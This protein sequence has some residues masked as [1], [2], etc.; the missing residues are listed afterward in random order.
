[1]PT[2]MCPNC[3]ARTTIDGDRAGPLAVAAAIRTVLLGGLAYLALAWLLNPIVGIV[4]ATAIAAKNMVS[5]FWAI[6]HGATT[7]HACGQT[8]ETR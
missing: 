8:F 2:A 7:C 4:G 3:L 5:V 6:D 1:M